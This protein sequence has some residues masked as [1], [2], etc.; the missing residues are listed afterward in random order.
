[1]KYWV[2]WRSPPCQQVIETGRR[3]PGEKTEVTEVIP[4]WAELRGLPRL[5]RRH[6]R[7]QLGTESSVGLSDM[8]A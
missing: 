6:S 2:R 7:R 4:A 3:R 8:F 5:F 1:M